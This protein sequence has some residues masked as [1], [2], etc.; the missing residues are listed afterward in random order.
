MVQR[1]LDRIRTETTPN[2]VTLQQVK[3]KIDPILATL[4]T[5]IDARQATYFATNGE[6]WQGGWSHTTQPTD[7]TDTSP[8][9][10]NQIPTN[11][12]LKWNQI[13]VGAEWPAQLP[14]RIRADVYNNGTWGYYLTVQV[15]LL[16]GNLWERSKNMRGTDTSKTVGWH[17]IDETPP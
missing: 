14:M 5:N 11:M 2:P 9:A 15:R 1:H 3:D 12:T 4:A 13:L 10:L 7:G 8:D 16:N 6:Y 17:L